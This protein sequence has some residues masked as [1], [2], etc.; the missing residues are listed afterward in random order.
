[1]NEN[2]LKWRNI[3]I[4]RYQILYTKVSYLYEYESGVQTVSVLQS[5]VW[6][7]ASFAIRGWAL[8][9]FVIL[10]T[11]EDRKLWV[12]TIL[13]SSISIKIARRQYKNYAC[14]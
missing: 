7:N 12:G 11:D 6:R 2:E 4:T 13:L 3:W 10:I 8:N 14:F 1:M 9:Y 5:G